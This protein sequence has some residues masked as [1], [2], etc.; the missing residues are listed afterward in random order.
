MA[1]ESFGG[2]PGADVRGEKQP[3][4]FSFPP[5][6]LLE[7]DHI[8]ESLASREPLGIRRRLADC[9]VRRGRGWHRRIGQKT[10]AGSG[11]TCPTM[12][13]K[14]NEP[15]VWDRR[16]ALDRILS[17]LPADPPAAHELAS[18]VGGVFRKRFRYEESDAFGNSD[19]LVKLQRAAGFVDSTPPLPPLEY[20]VVRL[21]TV[22]CL[23][24]FGPAESGEHGKTGTESSSAATPGPASAR[25]RAREITNDQDPRSSQGP[26][27]SLFLSNPELR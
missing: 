19:F 24:S 16:A 17:V 18:A 2:R 7:R 6:C 8:Q 10:R 27:S 14:T 4:S 22:T 21:K 20:A 1:A 5:F 25:A 15:K 23:A 11:V 12:A 9:A 13:A 26:R 3:R